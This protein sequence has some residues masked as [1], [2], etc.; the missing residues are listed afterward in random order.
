MMTDDE[1]RAKRRRYEVRET[2]AYRDGT[3]ER[4]E[5]VPLR[6]RIKP[7]TDFRA[8]PAKGSPRSFSDLRDA[9]RWIDENDTG[10]NPNGFLYEL[11]GRR[12]RR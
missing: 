5:G 12:R 6:S 2:I 10:G 3:I 9:K 4:R 11:Q 7:R 1:K 8:I